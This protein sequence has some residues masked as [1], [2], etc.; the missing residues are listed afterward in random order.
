M[1][2]TYG[3]NIKVSLFGASHAPAIGVTVEG[4]PAGETVDLQ[5]LQAFLERRAP[6]RDELSTARR[7]PDVPEFLSG[8][9]DSRTDGKPLKAVIRNTDARSGDYESIK[10]TP[11]P[12]H[13]DYTARVKYGEGFDMAGVLPTCMLPRR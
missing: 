7:E 11:R 12:G 10:D 6:G 9:T 3:K 1:N 2:T 4:L 8:L 13:A 5:E